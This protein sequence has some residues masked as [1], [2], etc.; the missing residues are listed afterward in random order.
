MDMK[1]SEL[2]GR[3]RRTVR[4]ALAR[5][6]IVVDGYLWSIEEERVVVVTCEVFRGSKSC[7]YD[8]LRRMLI[9]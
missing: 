5:E 8:D 1:V 7:R 4:D 3:E 9:G 6:A 2:R